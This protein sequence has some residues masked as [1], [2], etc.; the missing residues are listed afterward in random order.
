LRLYFVGYSLQDNNA[1]I[2]GNDVY[3]ES[4]VA[5]VAYFNPFPTTADVYT[6]PDNIQPLADMPPVRLTDGVQ[7]KNFTKENPTKTNIKNVCEE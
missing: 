4:W 5:T 2:F 1:E 7:I 3:M 6:N